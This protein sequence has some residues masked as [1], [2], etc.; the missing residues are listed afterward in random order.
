MST[1]ASP[2]KPDGPA[3][4][5]GT[6]EALVRG[7]S[8]PERLP[9]TEAQAAQL[10]QGQRFIHP[11]GDLALTGWRFGQGPQVLLVHGWSG[12][13][14]DLLPFVHPL[15][16]AGLGAVLLDLPA[17]GDSEGRVASPVHAGRAVLSV[18]RA[19]GNVQAMIAHSAG[20]AATLWALREGLR[21]RASVHLAGPAS[22]TPIVLAMAA[23]H[24]L[25]GPAT[26][27]FLEWIPTFTGEAVQA[28][29]LDSLRPGLRH[30]GLIVHAPEDRVVP[31][32]ASEALHAAWKDSVLALAPGL[33]HRGL[34][35]D[36]AIVASAVN[37]VASRAF[38]ETAV[39]S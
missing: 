22:M 1:G 39:P 18:A 26:Q 21:L 12:R 16:A 19:L 29:D 36:A 30:P 3:V 25:R 35:R 33:G 13:G 20:S 37:F 7:F 24:G 2:G 31:V 6:W 28:M 32:A 10:A 9:L 4:P 5:G 17:H 34:L 14:A 23:A 8:V 27:P 11:H 38:F 15:M